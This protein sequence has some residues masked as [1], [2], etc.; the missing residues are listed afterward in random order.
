MDKDK[1]DSFL[2]LVCLIN[3]HL[4]EQK[5]TIE[6]EFAKLL[7]EVSTYKK[8]AKQG[9]LKLE[10]TL[11]YRIF[12]G[13]ENLDDTLK[14]LD[15]DFSAKESAVKYLLGSGTEPSKLKPKP[16]LTQSLI[17]MANKFYQVALTSKGH[18]SSAFSTMKGWGAE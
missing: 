7:W 5:P 9:T 13:E 15:K 18:S 17:K 3:E 1:F 11:L 10:G 4:S 2:G 8:G 6:L 12:E 14:A 16:N